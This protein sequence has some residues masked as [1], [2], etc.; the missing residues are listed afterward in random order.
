MHIFWNTVD[1]TKQLK[2]CL[3]VLFRVLH[4]CDE[5]PLLKNEVFRRI[6]L[7]G[8]DLSVDSNNSNNNGG[9][10]G[11]PG[12]SQVWLE[13]IPDLLAAVKE[14]HSEFRA[15]VMKNKALFSIKSQAI[16]DYLS[17]IVETLGTYVHLCA[18]F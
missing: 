6:Q 18:S 12:K 2:L 13:H 3:D 17:D 15:L 16:E 1:T 10:G 11:S 7:I 14:G 9:G 4:S 5:A 8:L